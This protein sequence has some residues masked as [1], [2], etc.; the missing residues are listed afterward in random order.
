MK[1]LM[2]YRGLLVIVLYQAVPVGSDEYGRTRLGFGIGGGQLE[3]ANIGCDGSVIDAEAVGFKNAAAEVEHWFVPGKARVHVSG[4]YQWSDSLTSRGPFGSV[5]LS[6]EHQKF[7][8]GGGMSAVPA[9][10]WFFPT[11]DQYELRSSNRVDVFPTAY[12]RLG[13]RDKVHFRMDVFPV[14]INTPS[15][16][17]RM[18]AGFNQFDAR[19]ASGYFGIAAVAASFEES[20][21]TA[22][23]GEYFRPISPTVAI[24]GHGFLSAGKEHPQVGLSTQLRVTLH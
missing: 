3:Y 24:G 7:G 20:G 14:G 5:L 21:S 4:G 2:R 6:Y 1:S 8:V 22:I 16:V 19:R 10:V 18:G 13:D 12:L 15:E 17:V 11:P 23:F 9:S